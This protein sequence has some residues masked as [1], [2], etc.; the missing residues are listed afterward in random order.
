MGF[1]FFFVPLVS[2]YL[3]LRY[4]NYTRFS[5]GRESGYRLVF[6]SA[7]VGLILLVL[8]RLLVYCILHKHV[9]ESRLAN[10]DDLRRFHIPVHCLSRLC[11]VHS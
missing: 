7:A 2:G 1:G 11:S 10:W 6:E 8:A 9:L 5:I 3:F 4:C